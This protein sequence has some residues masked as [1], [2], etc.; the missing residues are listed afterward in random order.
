MKDPT[1]FTA[2]ELELSADIISHTT[3][4]AA[5]DFPY[6]MKPIYSLRAEA[7]DLIPSMCSDYSFLYYNPKWVIGIYSKNKQKLINTII[8]SVLH[9]LLLHPSMTT[10]NDKLFEAAADMAVFSMM[11]EANAISAPMNILAE[12]NKLL[13]DCGSRTT[14]EFYDKAEKSTAFRSRLFSVVQK[15]KEDDHSLWYT[16]RDNDEK[17]NTPPPSIQDS[18]QSQPSDEQEDGSA[19][20]S[21]SISELKESLKKD[22]EEWTRLLTAAQH[23]AA[24]QSYGSQAGNMFF[25]PKPPDRFSRFSYIEYLKRFAL[26]EVVAEDPD[27]LDIMMYHWGLDNLDNT[28]IVELCE[29]REL[30]CAS[31]IIIAIDV[32]GSCGGET[33]S[34]FLRQIYTLFTQMNIKSSVNINVVTFDTEITMEKKIRSRKDADSLVTNYN[35][36]GWGGTDFRCVFEYADNF[37]RK[38]RGKKLKGLFFFSDACGAFPDKKP[39]YR[40]TFFVPTNSDDSPFSYFN[41]DYVPDWVELVRYED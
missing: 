34:N 31:D 1:Q 8:H 19:Q 32:S 22:E 4:K 16:K 25:T 20:I 33:A 12:I 13:D 7:S 40:T 3:R 10:Q 2:E 28:P 26:K 14:S 36:G 38:N 39:S 6:M 35:P 17:N 37:S 30:C 5:A 41:L 27:T 24:S 29:T 9:S 18:P 21:V 23:S 11:H 15:L